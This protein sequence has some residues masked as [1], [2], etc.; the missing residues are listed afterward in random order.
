MFLG[1]QLFQDRRL[2]LID[3]MTCSLVDSQPSSVSVSTDTLRYDTKDCDSLS[4]RSTLPLDG[5]CN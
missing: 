2:G 1:R 5:G 4:R 3:L